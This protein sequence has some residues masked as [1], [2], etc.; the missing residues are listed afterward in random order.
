MVYATLRDS[1]GL[2]TSVTSLSLPSV[3]SL[4]GSN[5]TPGD[6][7]QLG[8]CLF[9]MPEALGSSPRTL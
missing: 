7:A 3:N 4:Q 9:G 2:V 5:T 1:C 6:V 8:V